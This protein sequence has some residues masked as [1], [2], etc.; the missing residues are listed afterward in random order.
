MEEKIGKFI[1][2]LRKEK[3]MTQQELAEKLNVTDRAVSHWENGRSVPDVSLF[4][5]ICNIFDISVSELVAGKRKKESKFKY[6][7]L[8]LILTFF[9]IIFLII[10]IRIYN[11]KF[12]IY[13]FKFY[14]IENDIYYKLTKKVTIDNRSV[15]NYGLEYEQVCDK[16]EKCFSIFDS[17]INK[18]VTL[19]DFKKYLDKQVKYQNYNIAFL[20]DKGTSIYTRDGLTIIYCDTFDNNN[21]IYIGNEK[22]LDSL[23][24]EYCGFSL[25]NIPENNFELNELNG[26][27][28]NIV[29]GTLTNASIKI[30]IYDKK[31][32]DYMYSSDYR[33][34]EHVDG[35][36]KEIIPK[37][38]IIS[39]SMVYEPDINGIL[40]FYI[41]WHSYYG[42]LAKG[43]YRIVMDAYETKNKSCSPEC[44]KKSYSVEF[45][46][47]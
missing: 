25:K 20:N 6:H 41:D 14:R 10:T 17:F 35:K 2:K 47:E 34:D 38:N 27:T 7:Y 9:L 33:I 30:Q 21:D 4:N 43:K 37:D 11:E 22:L 13:S 46:I 45:Y 31:I 26:V 24:G 23:N 15:Y 12:E 29:D 1:L 5:S 18:K 32:E 36:W 19:D 8:I 40:Y 44:K 16:N 28:A 3:N 42:N 39:N